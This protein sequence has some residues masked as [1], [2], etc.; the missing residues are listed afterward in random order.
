MDFHKRVNDI[1]GKQIFELSKAANNINLMS[2]A[3]LIVKTDFS[4]RQLY[5]DIYTT[6]MGK[7]GHVAKK[8]AASMSS[9]GMPSFFVHPGEAH[10]GDL[11]M[12]KPGSILFAFSNSGKTREVVSMIEQLHQLHPNIK[13]CAI[14]QSPDSPLASASQAGVYYGDIEEACH[15]KMAPTSSTLVMELIGNT[16]AIALSEK[17]DFTL[18]DFGDRHHGGYLGS[19]AKN[20]GD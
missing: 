16:I 15:I 14:T 5:C 18:Q 7:A 17:R 12:F 2:F 4:N 1:M 20:K 11:G 6:G 9:L 13:V 8:F 3:D 19:I 10:H